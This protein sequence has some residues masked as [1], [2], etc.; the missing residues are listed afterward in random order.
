MKN[1]LI[2]YTI[3]LFLT[4]LCIQ[5]FSQSNFSWPYYVDLSTNG[6]ISSD[7]QNI[8]RASIEIAIKN[9]KTDEDH[10]EIITRTPTIYEKPNG[11]YVLIWSDTKQRITN[12]EYDLI[13]QMGVNTF[14]VGNA[15]HKYGIIDTLNRFIL[16][17]KYSNIESA[18]PF[19]RFTDFSYHMHIENPESIKLP[20]LFF[21]CEEQNNLGVRKMIIR[22]DGKIIFDRPASYYSNFYFVK[23]NQI[24]HLFESFT[25]GKD[26]FHISKLGERPTLSYEGSYSAT[27]LSIFKTGF[28]KDPL[29]F[30]VNRKGLVEFFDLNKLDY[31]KSIPP[32]HNF[33]YLSNKFARISIKSKSNNQLYIEGIINSDFKVVVPFDLQYE[34]LYPLTE[35]IIKNERGEIMNPD[36]RVDIQLANDGLLTFGKS[37][38]DF[39]TGLS[40]RLYGIH[41]IGAGAILPPTY[42]NILRLT[43]DYCLVTFKEDNSKNLL[44]L[45][46]FKLVFPRNYDDIQLK[47]DDHGKAFFE[48]NYEGKIEKF[49]VPIL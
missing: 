48:C 5:S 6:F 17:L 33:D 27:P 37:V 46:N 9:K 28:I 29:V 30:A 2:R 25:N 7:Q 3:L 26:S 45:T 47:I 24:Y 44:E 31:I 49:N 11:K 19:V 18:D 8:L 13:V 23:N 39:R 10:K 41:K 12:N 40:M 4:Q 22:R 34:D 20:T 14:I 16:P 36:S 21:Y 1:L 32:F 38:K 35:N 43:K 42:L 15:N